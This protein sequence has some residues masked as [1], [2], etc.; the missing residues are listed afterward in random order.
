MVL[1]PRGPGWKAGPSPLHRVETTYSTA[2]DIR[3]EAWKIQP[4]EGTWTL[5]KGREWGVFSRCRCEGC[6]VSGLWV[7]E[8]AV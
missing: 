7:L 4:R 5:L 8:G 2:Q 3:E 1:V 6:L